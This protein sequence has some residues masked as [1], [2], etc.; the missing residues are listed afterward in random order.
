M[1]IV[2]YELTPN[3]RSAHLNTGVS[4]GTS[5]VQFGNDLLL[6]TNDN[7][8]LRED[9]AG[10]AERSAIQ[11]SEQPANV[12]R[13]SLHIVVQRGRLFQQQHPKIPV[14]IDHGRFLLVEIDPQQA[15]QL[16]AKMEALYT[17]RPFE[18][19]EVVFDV[20][21]SVATRAPVSQIQQ[22]VDKVSRSS[23]KADLVHLVS[24][25]TRLSTSQHYA[26]VAKWVAAQLKKMSYG[27]H[28]Q[29]ITV[30]TGK[31]QNII[32]D[33]LGSGVGIRGL[34]LVTAHLDSINHEDGALAIA[35]GAD[36]NGS[37]S[38][39]LLQIARALQSHAN[40]H[41][42]RFVFFGGEEQG[43]FGSKQYVASL[44]AKEQKRIRAVVNMDMIASLNGDVPT[45][46]LE[47][48]PLSQS[49]INGLSAAAQTYTK[50][51][52]QVS[53]QPFASDHVS[54]IE[55]GIPSVLTIEGADEKNES[56]HSSRDTIDRINYDLALE[57]LRM[58][59]AF[60]AT[61]SS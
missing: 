31:S 55:K 12:S 6:Y 32:A 38:A 52:V 8:N 41:D 43:L 34:I 5:W 11:L 20:P 14:I 42:L 9:V 46:L 10:S 50:L 24:Y 53:L 57:I 15:Q 28:S 27:T 19:N 17:L 61:I 23:F 47:G 25:P 49:M 18:D 30:N 45:V 39:G 59:V 3:N 29:S 1:K 22:L 4:H 36:D 16:K 56:E 54:F 40:V 21:E 51:T 37:G 60:V 48:A 2:K 26:D 13:E 7:E 58:N 33:K 35:P 44:S